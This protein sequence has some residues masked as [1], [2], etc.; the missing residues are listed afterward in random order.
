M[1]LLFAFF[2]RNPFLAQG[3]SA[4]LETERRE[5]KKRGQ[6]RMGR[7]KVL[8]KKAWRQVIE[9]SSRGKLIIFLNGNWN[10]ER[11]RSLWFT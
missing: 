9:V 5:K 8:C 3:R 6:I 11:G 1:T 4:F 2:R 7:W 10:K